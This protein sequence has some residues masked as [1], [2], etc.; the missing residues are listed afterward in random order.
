MDETDRKFFPCI[1]NYQLCLYCYEKLTVDP[2]KANCPHCRK[3]YT[4]N[5]DQC[6]INA[7]A[8]LDKNNHKNTTNNTS[9][10][11]NISTTITNHRSS[12]NNTSKNI[13]SSNNSS[14]NTHHVHSLLSYDELSEIRVRQKNLV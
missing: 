7:N 3:P 2:T 6:R 10:I 13:K 14:Q 1:C 4:R 8:E 5:I 9:N 11:I 12:N